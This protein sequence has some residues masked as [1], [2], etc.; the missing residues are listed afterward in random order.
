MRDAITGRRPYDLFSDRWREYVAPEVNA[1]R[2][3]SIFV[4]DSV[5]APF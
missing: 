5:F 4:L 2:E 1:L 3:I